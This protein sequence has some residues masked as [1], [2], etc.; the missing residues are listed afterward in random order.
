MNTPWSAVT[1]CI[2]GVRV[3]PTP[4]FNAPAMRRLREALGMAPGHV[5]YGLYAQYGL[6]VSPR[7]SPPGNG[8]S[9][10]PTPV[11]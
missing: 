4:P 8:A 3:H 11:S 9:K 10:R 7:P 1:L 6:R 2:Y 5:A